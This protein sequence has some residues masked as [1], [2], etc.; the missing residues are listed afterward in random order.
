ML[1]HLLNPAVRAPALYRIPSLLRR[2]NEYA[3]V[4]WGG[5]RGIASSTEIP[6]RQW[7]HHV[8]L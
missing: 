2:V 7:V 5:R 8:A 1:G 3:A 6:V 4:D